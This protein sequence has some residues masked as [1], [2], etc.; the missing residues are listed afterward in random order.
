MLEDW[1]NKLRLMQTT[2][3]QAAINKNEAALP[4]LRWN[5][6][7][8]TVSGKKKSWVQNN[9]L[10]IVLFLFKEGRKSLSVHVW[11]T[12]F[13]KAIQNRL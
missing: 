8:N 2:E 6:F 11:N 4:V 5:R 7:Q 9:A 1:L 12:E 13:W 10:W 3:Y